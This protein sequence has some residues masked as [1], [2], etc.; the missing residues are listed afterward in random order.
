[1]ARIMLITPLSLIDNYTL[2]AT[3]SPYHIPTITF[4]KYLVADTTCMCYPY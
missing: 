3:Y 2:T 1:M 4:H